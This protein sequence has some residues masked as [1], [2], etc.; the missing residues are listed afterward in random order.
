[1]GLDSRLARDIAEI[2]DGLIKRGAVRSR[3]QLD[4]SYDAFR[5]RFGPDTLS[6]LDGEALLA[7][8]HE[9]GTSDSLVYWLEFKDDAEFSTKDFGSI[10]GGS[11]LKFGIYKGAETGSWMTGNP[12]KQAELSV[13]EAVEVARRNRDQLILGVEAITAAR[14]A[15]DEDYRG[16]QVELA[17]VAPDVQDTVW[18]HKYFTLVFPEA[19]ENYHARH[20]QDYHLIRLLQVPPQ[21]DGRYVCAWRYVALSRDVGIRLDQLSKVLNRRHGRPRRYWRVGTSHSGEPGLRN[22]W[23]LMRDGSCVAIGWDRLGDLSDVTRTME[24]KNRVRDLIAEKYPETIPQE[25]GRE[26]EEVFSFVANIREDDIVVAMAG[27]TVLGIGRVTGEYLHDPTSDFPHRRPVEWLSLAEW[28]MPQPEGLRRTVRELHRHPDNLV[29]VERHILGDMV[30]HPP[31]PGTKPLPPLPA[32]IRRI[33]SILERKRQVILFGPPGTGKTFW[34]LSA[35]K[36]LC[37]RGRFHKPYGQLTASERAEME[38]SLVRTCCFHPAYGYEDFIE[39]YRPTARD[40]ALTFRL[41]DGIFKQVC[42]SAE[43]NA[44][45]KHFLVIDEIN[46]GDIPRIFGELLTL[47]EKDRRGQSLVLPLSGADFRVPQNVYVIGTMNTADRSIALLDVALRRRFGFLEL[48]P[49]S[50]LLRDVVVE[51]LPLGPW[52][53]ALNRRICE[54]V[55]RDARNLQIGHAYLMDKGRPVASLAALARAIRDDVAPLLQEY[56][57]EDYSALERILGPKLI[58]VDRHRIRTELFEEPG[59]PA[60]LD[61]LLDVYKDVAASAQAVAAEP[62]GALVAMDEEA[63]E[64]DEN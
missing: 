12:R 25:V 15:S 61:A 44:E 18:G 40:G 27:S 45:T 34:A 56:C 32:V 49:D 57:Y 6:G 64:D 55:G 59:W 4:R 1:M 53:E 36:E 20:F 50:A 11:A 2:H 39:G 7:A 19:F 47:M 54:H 29:E 52:L 37:S 10:G 48:M 42:A 58:D 24:Q 14:L 38:D 28:Q 23:H 13:D 41:Q 51:D 22:R 26:K 3:Q 46:R 43:I 62:D 31:G 8:M 16:L 63:E 9:H 60:L 21:E 35:A 33:E 5:Q 17:E 30:Q